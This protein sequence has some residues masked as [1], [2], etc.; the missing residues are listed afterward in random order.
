MP[1]LNTEGRQRYF[2]DATWSSCMCVREKREREREI[3]R[4]RQ[5]EKQTENVCVNQN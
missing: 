5:R 1:L 3:D 4:Q 2:L